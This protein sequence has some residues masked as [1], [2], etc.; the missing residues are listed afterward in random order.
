MSEARLQNFLGALATA[1]TDRLGAA[2]ERL[3]EFGGEAAAAVVQIGTV[4]NLTIL[5]LS[6]A[7]GLSHSATTRVVSKLALRGLVLKADG[8]DG[9]EVALKLT[10]EGTA[11]MERILV[12]RTAALSEFLSVLTKEE[13]LR[14][15]D[16]FARMLG[17]AP[18]DEAEALRI[19]RLCDERACPQDICPVTTLN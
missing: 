2:N 8:R 12:S 7:L 17:N 4:P 9:R 19:C 18:R 3:A 13:Q 11:L 16:A 5:M 14:L 1:V 6:K 10:D 15:E